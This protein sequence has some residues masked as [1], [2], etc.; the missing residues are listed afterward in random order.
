MNRSSQN[1]NKWFSFKFS[2]NSQKIAKL[3]N[4]APKYFSSKVDVCINEPPAG[5]FECNALITRLY[6]SASATQEI[7]PLA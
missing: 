6:L 2:R 4:F 1:E 7:V 3:D 5:S